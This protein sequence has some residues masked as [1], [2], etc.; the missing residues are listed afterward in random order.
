MTVA[1]R[2]GP[3]DPIITR[4]MIILLLVLPFREIVGGS[5]LYG[6]TMDN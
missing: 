2:G 4:M 5:F 1:S 3:P 6:K